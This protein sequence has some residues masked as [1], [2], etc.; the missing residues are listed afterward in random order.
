MEMQTLQTAG[1]VHLE[2]ASLFLAKQGFVGDS[3]VDGPG[4]RCAIFCQG[5][6]HGCP[7]C[8]NP[9][10]HPFEGGVRWGVPALLTQI[11]RHPLCR[12]VT[13]SG[14]EPFCQ[15]EA[16]VPLAETLR[17]EGYELAAYTGYTFE[18]LAE[19]GSPAQKRLLSL[20]HTLVDGPFLLAQKNLTLRF[21]GSENQRI[22]DMPKSLAEGRAVAETA[23]RWTGAPGGQNAMPH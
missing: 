23:P 10:T 8:H 2:G 7:G 13:F 17:A 1:G 5:C 20:L 21:R 16:L 3:I 12:G 9:E 18:H 6:P 22:L 4:L 19:K 15:A 11:H 14:G